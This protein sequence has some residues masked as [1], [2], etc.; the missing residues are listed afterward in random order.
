MKK[1]TIV[2]V[3]DCIDTGENADK[4]LLKIEC[5]GNEDMEASDGYHT[6]G[7]LYDHRIT[8]FIVLCSWISNVCA[9]E[10][11]KEKCEVWR[12]KLHSDGSFLE[13]WFIL[14]INKAPGKQITYH[15]PLSR[16]YDTDFAETL[17]CAP[18]WDGHTP[19][20]VIKRL[21]EL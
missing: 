19:S 17:E 13:G 14:G 4:R 15:L 6:F 9:A 10:L 7:E 18:E 3:N 2:N 21:Q 8:L 11:A 1:I 16:W 5:E 20:D 12:S